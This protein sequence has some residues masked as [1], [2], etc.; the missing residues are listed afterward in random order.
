MARGAWPASDTYTFQLKTAG[1]LST[2]VVYTMPKT[3]QTRL[4]IPKC[5]VVPAAYR[6]KKSA[7]CD[8]LSIHY[9]LMKSHDSKAIA[10]PQRYS[11]ANSNYP[12]LIPAFC[13]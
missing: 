1:R 3:S 10:V 9:E 2:G 8:P 6:L 4:R 13:Q 11:G 12:T 5:R 7:T